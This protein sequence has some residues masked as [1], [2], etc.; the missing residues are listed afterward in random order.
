M[1]LPRELLDGLKRVGFRT[2]MGY[3]DAGF[4]L[5]AW[6]RAGGYYL[7]KFS[8]KFEDR[9]SNVFTRTDVGASQL[10]IDGKIKLKAG[11][12]IESFTRTGMKFAD[13]STHDADV[14]LFATGYGD[15]REPI[16]QILGPELGQKLPPIWGLTEEGELRGC[17]KELNIPNLW[18]IMGNFAMCRFYSA[19]LAL[20]TYHFVFFLSGL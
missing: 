10:I 3:K 9:K 20:R 12:S 1:R 5:L 15:P 11:S 19:R 16:R 4:L 7:G 13:G 14:V 17:W 6:E 18:L 2:N 8:T